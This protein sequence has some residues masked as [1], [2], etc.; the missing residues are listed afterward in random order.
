MLNVV[1]R[2]CGLIGGEKHTLTFSPSF[3]FDER[4]LQRE[5]DAI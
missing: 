4:L 1:W 3:V 5:R 2:Q